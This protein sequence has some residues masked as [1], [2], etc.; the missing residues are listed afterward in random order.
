AIQRPKKANIG[1]CWEVGLAQ[2]STSGRNVIEG[3]S[4]WRVQVVPESD[5]RDRKL[6]YDHKVITQ[7]RSKRKL[8]QVSVDGAKGTLRTPRGVTVSA[9]LYR[10]HG[11]TGDIA[12]LRFNKRRGIFE[13]PLVDLPQI[14][15]GKV[16]LTLVVRAKELESRETLLLSL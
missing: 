7:G 8:L 6:S 4:V 12:P 1:A 5:H 15:H 10:K 13:L 9:L 14:A 11:A 16:R 2:R 3:G